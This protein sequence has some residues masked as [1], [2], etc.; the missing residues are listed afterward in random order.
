MSKF[1][2]YCF[3]LYRYRDALHWKRKGVLCVGV[4][5]IAV[6]QDCAACISEGVL[7]IF[8]NSNVDLDNG[9]KNS[10]SCLCR[11][12]GS[13]RLKS[14]EETVERVCKKIMQSPRKLL[15]RTSLE[16]QISPTRVWRILRKR[17]IMK[18]YKLRLVQAMM[19][20]DRRKRKPN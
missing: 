3:C 19:A 15:R 10:K 16:S 8:A 2:V 7:K 13:G 6:G 20:E 14:S 4:C 1:D 5:W 12:K 18:P 11:R 17:L 9:A